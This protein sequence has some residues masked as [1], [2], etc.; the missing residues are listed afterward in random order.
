MMAKTTKPSY[1]RPGMNSRQANIYL[2]M[3]MKP[4]ITLNNIPRISTILLN[5]RHPQTAFQTNTAPGGKVPA[6]IWFLMT[7]ADRDHW[8]SISPEH[9]SK[10]LEKNNANPYSSG[11][12]PD[13][14][15]AGRFGSS[16]RS[17]RFGRGPG[18]GRGHGH[19]GRGPGRGHSRP[20]E[21]GLTL[22]SPSGYPS[23]RKRTDMFTG[24]RILIM[25]VKKPTT[26]RILLEKS[27][28]RPTACLF[29]TMIN[30]K[31]TKSASSS[32]SMLPRPRAPSRSHQRL[33]KHP[34]LRPRVL[35]KR[36]PSL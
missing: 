25:Q 33:Q 8:A 22:M 32:L 35:H 23:Q 24:P 18:R 6:H 15:S 3:M 31:T 16:G 27:S 28:P 30:S 17:G 20:P 12:P 13:S 11:R 5:M 9:R 36:L 19:S 1:L 26:N 14:R 29:P 10:I 21:R 7:D 34:R 2:R 4:S